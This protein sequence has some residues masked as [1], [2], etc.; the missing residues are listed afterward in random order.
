MHRISFSEALAGITKYF[1]RRQIISLMEYRIFMNLQHI[2]HV[3]VTKPRYQ[4][5][6]KKCKSLGIPTGF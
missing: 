5:A 4:T 2:V 3:D 6:E 1:T